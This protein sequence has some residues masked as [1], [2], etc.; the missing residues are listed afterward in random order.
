MS[1]WRARVRRRAPLSPRENSLGVR[2]RERRERRGRPGRGSVRRAPGFASGVWVRLGAAAE[3]RRAE[4]VCHPAS[5]TRPSTRRRATVPRRARPHPRGDRVSFSSRAPSREPR[6][7]RPRLSRDVSESLPRGFLAAG[8][9]RAKER[10]APSRDARAWARRARARRRRVPAP[11]RARRATWRSGSARPR[12][13]PR[14]PRRAAPRAR[15]RATPRAPARGSARAPSG[16]GAWRRARWRRAPARRARRAPGAGVWTL[17]DVRRRKQSPGPR[18]PDA[19]VRGR[20]PPRGVRR[21]APADLAPVPDQRE[22]R[23]ERRRAARLLRLGARA[24]R[25]TARHLRHARA[26]SGGAREGVRA[27]Q[28]QAR[29]RARACPARARA[30]TPA[31]RGKTPRTALRPPREP[32]PRARSS[33]KTRG[34]ASRRGR[35]TSPNALEIRRAP[36]GDARV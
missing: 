30:T 31:R 20:V 8:K 10:V 5:A 16:A 3:P 23:G 35:R 21:D 17:P 6:P 26:R 33:R 12:A 22:P 4:T 19:F 29:A 7:P 2:E 1:G 25:T 32:P 14:A 24:A 9:G 18:R 28:S 27:S 36:P 15:P 13:G 34:G 11:R